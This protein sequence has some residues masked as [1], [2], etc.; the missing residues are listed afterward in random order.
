VLAFYRR[1]KERE[2]RKMRG[3]GNTT[4]DGMMR[5]VHIID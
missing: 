4:L 5:Y 3:N 2:K 1:I